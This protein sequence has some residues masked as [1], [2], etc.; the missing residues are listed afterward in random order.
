MLSLTGMLCRFWRGALC[1]V[2][3]KEP[4]EETAKEESGENKADDLTAIRGISIVTQI[5]LHKAGIKT[6]AA[7]A[8][9]RPEEL[10]EMLGDVARGAKIE[11]WI[12]QARELA[13]KETS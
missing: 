10:R 6:Y 12:T 8:G 4:Q 9:A 1:G 3:R 5:Q 11:R 2:A 7:L 13:G